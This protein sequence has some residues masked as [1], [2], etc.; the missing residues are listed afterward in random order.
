MLFVVCLL[1]GLVVRRV[2]RRLVDLAGFGFLRCL[3]DLIRT[4][5]LYF[6]QLVVV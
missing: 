4:F 3:I 2:I 5:V 6:I 1:C